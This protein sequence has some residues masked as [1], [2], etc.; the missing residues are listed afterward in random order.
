MIKNII[1]SAA[2]LT[3]I[4]FTVTVNSVICT[5]IFKKLCDKVQEAQSLED[6]GKL[7]DEIKKHE[8]YLSFTI[9]NASLAEIRYCTAEL[10]A[11]AKEN[12]SE[13]AEAAKSRLYSRLDEQ[14]RL[15]GF[16]FSSIF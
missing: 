5:N 12:N 11:Y 7:E 1:I 3:A 4:F 14:R 10:Y 16:N 6:Y 8:F 13:E 9:G 2:A 15:S